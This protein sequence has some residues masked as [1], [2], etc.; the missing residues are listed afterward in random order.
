[1]SPRSLFRGS[2]FVQKKRRPNHGRA[3]RRPRFETFEDRRMLSFTPAVNYATVG[4]PSAIVAADFNNDGNLDLATCANASIGSFSVLLGDG[5][6]GFG[7]ALRTVIGSQL[8]SIAVADFNNDTRP[9]MVVSDSGGFRLL[10]GNGDGTFQAGVPMMGGDMAAVGDFNNDGNSDVVVTWL[11]GDWWSHVQVYRG[12]GQGGFAAGPD[13]YYW[14]YSGLAAVDL[15]NDGNL[16]VATGDGPAFLGDGTGGL[17]FDW[18]QQAQHT[19]GAIATGDFTGDG[20]ADAIVAS[21]TVA[22]LRGRGDGRFDAPIT[23]PAAGTPHTAVATADFNADGK[24]DAIVTESDTGTV[25]LLLGN[26][27]G[28]LRFGGTFATGA[29]PSDVVVGDFNR[30]GRPDVAVSNA[31]ADART[32]S[33]L[34]NDGNWQTTPPQPLPPPAFSVNDVTVTEGNT[35]TRNATF[36]LSLSKPAAVAVSVNYGTADISASSWIDYDAI[37]GRVTIPAGQTSATFTIPVRGDWYPEPT[38]TFAVNLNSPANAMI[39]DAQGIGTIV[40]DD[41]APRISINDVSKR[42]GNSGTSEIAFTV[43]LTAAYG[44]AVIVNYATANGT[45][46]AGRDYQSRSG[47]VTFAPGEVTKSISVMVLG[48]RKWEANETFFVNLSGGTNS[49]ISDS[50]GVATIVNDDGG[51]LRGTGDASALAVDMAIKEW[52][53]AGRKRRD[54]QASFHGRSFTS[55]RFVQDDMLQEC[56]RSRTPPVSS[57]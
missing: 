27:D 10:V 29:A 14:G 16:D 18:N 43:S 33:I 19:G 25:G 23:H 47:S 42:E 49:G 15:N 38:E 21:Y 50:Q 26:G 36:T 31:A 52:M 41:Q 30:D 56:A 51:R 46:R 7:A 11:D 55:L 28:T 54:R 12:N 9:D 22:V 8:S 5:A 3:T 57:R 6:G 45:A 35:G 53:H 44:E 1:M 39:S 13:A 40:D 2:Q 24:L 48:D 4:T 32:V 17:H 20:N 34:L 37:G